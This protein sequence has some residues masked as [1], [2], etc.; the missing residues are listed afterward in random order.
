M[1]ERKNHINIGDEIQIP[2]N[3]FLAELEKKA[4]IKEDYATDLENPTFQ[5]CLQCWGCFTGWL[6]TWV[7]GC[8][9]EAPYRRIPEAHWAVIT[10]FGKYT[11]TLPPGLHYINPKTEQV[12]LVDR[13]EKVINLQKQSIITK[14]NVNIQ[15]DAI[16]FYFTYDPYK[17][18]FEVSNLPMSIAEIA[19]TTLRDVFG[20]VLLQEAFESREKIAELIKEVVDK[21]TEKWGVDITRVLIQEIIIPQ[22]LLRGLASAATAKREAEA[23]VIQ[24]QADVDSAKL[25]REASDALNTPAAMQIR[26][27]DAISALGQARNTKVVFMPG[28]GKNA[29][30]DVKQVK[31]FLVQSELI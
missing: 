5:A 20:N 7:C 16:V 25:M 12:L 15:I 27:L 4:E 18:I 9:C 17:S 19:K 28:E 14:D 21:P 24:A 3:K 30:T 8:C 23:K 10:E 13:R 1:E 29:S 11:R 22:D 26:Y 2:E 6:A 31:N